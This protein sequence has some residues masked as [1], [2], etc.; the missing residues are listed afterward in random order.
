MRRRRPPEPAARATAFAILQEVEAGRGHSHVLL[1]A[2]P[3]GMDERERALA[4]ELVYGVLRRRRPLDRLIGLASKR[5]LEGIDLPLRILL[6]LALYQI[7][8]LTRVPRSAAVDESVELARARRV[9]AA[10]AFVN[11]VLRGACR[12]LD[13]R[14]RD[15]MPVPDRAADPAAYLEETCSF[16]R[17]LVAR[18]LARHGIDEAEALL[19]AMNR[20]APVVLRVTRRGGDAGALAR[21]LEEEG[22]RT[23]PSPILP[24]ALRVLEGAPQHSKPFRDGAIYIQDEASQMVARLLLPIGAGDGLLD[25]C[26]A[27]G[28]K[29]LAAAEEASPGH[30]LLIAADRD[31]WRLRVLGE[32]ARRLR[33]G[34]IHAVA[35]DA[36]RPAVR[37]RFRRILLDAPCSGTG[38]IRRHPEIRWRRSEDDI[39][40]LARRQAQALDAAA[41]L[42]P[43]GGRLVY[44][45]CSLEP[46]EG[47]RQIEALLLRRAD[48]RAVDARP[49]LPPEAR[50]AVDADGFLATLPH[51]HDVDGFFAAVVE[52]R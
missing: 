26:A 28:G 3:P 36:A 22:I 24:G 30:G 20:P 14:G 15:A 10:A 42:L 11:G 39:A 4:T 40:T 33:V 48:L 46:E 6:R 25:L 38:I 41:G 34:G 44:A 51:R 16:P 52:F 7:L 31:R 18:V 17:F 43:P 2:M 5:S 37:G 29:I 32:N 49:L 19:Q 1:A 12:I 23:A 21:R 13:E 35:M 47:P 9:E 27:P 45:V 50:G 8:F